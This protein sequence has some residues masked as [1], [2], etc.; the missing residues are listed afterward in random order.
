[1]RLRRPGRLLLPAAGTL[2]TAGRARGYRRG[3][4]RDAHPDNPPEGHE[5]AS[6][7]GAGNSGAAGPPSGRES[8]TGS[9]WR[10]RVP[11]APEVPAAHPRI[12]S[13]NGPQGYPHR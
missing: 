6:T 9:S 3:H 8:D 2:P 12:P 11:G 1:L 7:L 4:R 10:A 13:Y 5:T